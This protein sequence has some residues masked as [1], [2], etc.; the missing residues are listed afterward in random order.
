[1]RLGSLP[2]WPLLMD[3]RTAAAFLSS[4]VRDFRAAVAAGVLPKHRTMHERLGP[5]WH[6][7]ELEAVAARFWGLDRLSPANQDGARTAQEALDAFTPPAPARR[8][9]AVRPVHSG[10]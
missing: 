8:T 7:A 5:L 6:R 3:E 10:A 4:N 1:M 9:P 2:G